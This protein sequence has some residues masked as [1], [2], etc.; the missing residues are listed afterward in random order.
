[1]MTCHSVQKGVSRDVPGGPALSPCM[2][3]PCLAEMTAGNVGL[4]SP[5]GTAW[6]VLGHRR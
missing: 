2:Q 1:M 4:C 6:W 3:M 5:K